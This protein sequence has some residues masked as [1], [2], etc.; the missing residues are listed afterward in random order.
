[1]E[2]LKLIYPDG[3]VGGTII[4]LL[5]CFCSMVGVLILRRIAV[6]GSLWYQKNRYEQIKPQI[7]AYI[8]GEGELQLPLRKYR[9]HTL[10]DNLIKLA[11]LV[12]GQEKK[13]LRSLY[14]HFGFMKEDYKSFY[15]GSRRQSTLALSRF[16]L[17]E[18]PLKDEDWLLLI[19]NPNPI[20]RWAAMEYLIQKKRKSSLFWISG[21]LTDHTNYHNGIL[22][23]LFCTIAQFAPE[24]ILIILKYTDDTR[25]SEQCLKT[26]SVY[27]TPNGEDEIIRHM[28]DEISDEG[29]ISAVRALSG[30]ITPKVLEVFSLL[31]TYHHWVVRLIIAQSLGR[32]DDPV[33][34]KM[35]M[36]LTEDVNYYVRRHAVMSLLQLGSSVQPLLKTIFDDKEHPSHELLTYLSLHEGDSK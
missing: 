14:Q 13:R 2:Y 24:L 20:F 23:H 16:R 26:L 4:L 1:M 12:S 11:H 31:L 15:Y 21:F 6:N 33:A 10:R 3:V 18:F 28:N 30:A 8:H 29:Y 36:K 34:P 9:S 32:I 22:Q 35:L 25:V 5:F 19:T 27:P 7:L 17:L